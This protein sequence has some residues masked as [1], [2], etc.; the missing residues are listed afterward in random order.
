M[1]V[2]LGDFDIKVILSI[3]KHKRYSIEKKF[4]GKFYI[5]KSEQGEI[6][7]ISSFG[8]QN[9]IIKDDGTIY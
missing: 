5:D 4:D 6:F 3:S 2:Y 8:K 9:L 1:S 7:K